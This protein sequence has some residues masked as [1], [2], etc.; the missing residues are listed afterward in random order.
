MHTFL[1]RCWLPTP[2]KRAEQASLHFEKAAVAFNLGA[3]Q[4]GGPAAP[5]ACACT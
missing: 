1:A 5:A 4:V 2:Q 3:V